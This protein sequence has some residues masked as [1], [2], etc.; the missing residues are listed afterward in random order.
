MKAH[1]PT[2]T[3]T[4]MFIAALYIDK[5]WRKNQHGLQQVN[6][7]IHLSKQMIMYQKQRTTTQ[8]KKGTS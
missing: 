4:Q 2:K 1:V 3:G 5:N 7:N 8:Q 6:E